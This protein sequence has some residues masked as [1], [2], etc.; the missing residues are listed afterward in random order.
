MQRLALDRANA[1]IS[2]YLKATTGSCEGGLKATLHLQA[3]ES[4]N[5]LWLS[6]CALSHLPVSPRI[7][8][9]VDREQVSHFIKVLG[10]SSTVTLAA[11]SPR[12]FKPEV[13]PK[14]EVDNGYVSLLALREKLTEE[15]EKMELTQEALADDA[16]SLN[17]TAL[18]HQKLSTDAAK[19]GELVKAWK[20]KQRAEV[21]WVS[22]AAW[23]LTLTSLYIFARRVA[24]SSAGIRVDDWLSP[25]LWLCH[26][27]KLV[28]VK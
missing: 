10:K 19:S 17:S 18:L 8:P 12:D 16:D 2:E 13:V 24:W 23:L 11:R 7:D 4:V 1:R 9:G 15:V 14:K 28:G 5:A 20:R 6:L 22:A 25:W 26:L 27:L 3:E 21:G